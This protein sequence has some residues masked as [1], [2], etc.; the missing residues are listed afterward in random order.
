MY[1]N[2]AGAMGGAA[3]MVKA[4][5]D[6]NDQYGDQQKKMQQMMA[7]RSAQPGA[8]MNIQPSTPMAQAPLPSMQP[9]PA[10]PMQGGMPLPSM[11]TQPFPQNGASPVNLDPMTK[12]LFSPIPG[13][14]G[15]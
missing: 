3:G 9:Q 5:M 8:P 4:L 11:G 2:P 1:F 10:G 15:Q 13:A 12:A 7:M 14:G 6:G